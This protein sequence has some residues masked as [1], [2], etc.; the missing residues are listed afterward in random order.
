VWAEGGFRRL[1]MPQDETG[2][3]CINIAEDE[4]INIAEDEY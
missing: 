2:D 3:G 1:K 4:C